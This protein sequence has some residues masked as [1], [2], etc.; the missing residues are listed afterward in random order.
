MMHQSATRLYT[1]TEISYLGSTS[2]S[3]LDRSVAKPRRPKILPLASLHFLELC[4]SARLMM[5]VPRLNLSEQLS[6]LR[7]EPYRWQRETVRQLYL[8]KSGR[9]KYI[10]NH[11]SAAGFETRLKRRL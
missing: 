10:P 8:L 9:G 11:N 1:S 7:D 2:Q 6:H 3:S 4:F 5:S